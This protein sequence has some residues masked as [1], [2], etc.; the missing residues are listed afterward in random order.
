M[1]FSKLPREAHKKDTFYLRVKAALLAEAE[2]PWFTAVPV[3]RNVL[4]QMMK[5]M[6]TEE[7][8]EKA[9][10]NHSLRSYGISKTFR[11]D[12]PEKLI[13]EKSGHRSLEGV[14]QYERTS[15]LQ[16]VQVCKVLETNE[17]FAQPL[18]NPTPYRPPQTATQPTS[19]FRGASLPTNTF[20]LS[21]AYKEDYSDI[22]SSNF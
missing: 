11:G 19:T 13:M 15:A 5:A 18:A 9:V 17:K 8:L 10:T 16:E 4:G 22:D 7:K 14:R 12:V 2:D 20:Q 3:G 1:Y 6:A 21:K